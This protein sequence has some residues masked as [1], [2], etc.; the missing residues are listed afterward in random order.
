M[1]IINSQFYR[2]RESERYC[3]ADDYTS[4]QSHVGVSNGHQQKYIGPY[5]PQAGTHCG[6]EH[7]LFRR[8]WPAVRL[9]CRYRPM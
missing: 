5:R 3:R 9:A 2:F 7:S 1:S 6:R 4:R 8:Q